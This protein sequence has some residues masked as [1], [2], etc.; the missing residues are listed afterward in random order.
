F[1]GEGEQRDRLK[2]FKTRGPV[3]RGCVAAVFRVYGYLSCVTALFPPQVFSKPVAREFES[4][5]LQEPGKQEVARFEERNPLFVNHL[6]LREQCSYFEV[7]EGG[8]DNEELGGLV[9][10]V[11]AAL[12]VLGKVGNELIGDQ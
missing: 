7:Q 3:E 11:C 1:G 2:V 8:R 4:T 5:V 6:A 12:F 10:V 9:E